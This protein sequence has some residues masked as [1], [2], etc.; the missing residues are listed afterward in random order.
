MLKIYSLSLQMRKGS[1]VG[2]ESGIEKSIAISATSS[3]LLAAVGLF[4]LQNLQY[5]DILNVEL[6]I[7]D[8]F[9]KGMCAAASQSKVS[10][11]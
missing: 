1:L 8:D 11:N 7:D 3:S 6:H 2:E 10:G 4:T 9:Y 5:L